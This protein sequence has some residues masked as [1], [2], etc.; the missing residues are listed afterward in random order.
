MSDI[1]KSF[2]RR[3]MVLTEFGVGVEDDARVG[4]GIDQAYDLTDAVELALGLELMTFGWPQSEAAEFIR[5]NRRLLRNKIDSIDVA[6]T[7]RTLVWILPQPYRDALQKDREGTSSLSYYVPEF[8][9]GEEEE[10]S[11]LKKI[12]T[13][14]R[15]RLVFD[16]GSMKRLLTENLPQAPVI[17]RG[18]R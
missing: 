11:Q 1:S 7:T 5:K 3:V 15:G 2:E 16:L 8:S 12:T 18:R 14:F 17:R 4:K 6:S 9:Y 13:V 10:A